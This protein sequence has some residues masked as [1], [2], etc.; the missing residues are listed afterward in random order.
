MTPSTFERI[1]VPKDGS[2][3]YHA[4]MKS[5]SNTGI[6]SGHEISSLRVE[7]ATWMR[8]HPGDVVLNV[9][10]DFLQT[11]YDLTAGNEPGVWELALRGVCENSF[12]EIA[13]IHAFARA[14]GVDVVVY[15]KAAQGQLEVRHRFC[16]AAPPRGTA[17]VLLDWENVHY[18]ALVPR[19]D[20][21]VCPPPLP[22]S[23]A[24]V[25][26]YMHRSRRGGGWSWGACMM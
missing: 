12:A 18:E 13:V 3:F 2:C 22:P 24:S 10:G 20:A 11:V 17:H 1:A 26:A 8:K 25:R 23:L 16:G 7:T 5:L 15:S 14:F 9:G 19:V 4:V 6:F 21:V